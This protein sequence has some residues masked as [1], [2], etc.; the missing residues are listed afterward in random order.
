VPAEH[1]VPW[2]RVIRSSGHIAFPAGSRGWRR[3]KKQL[4]EEGVTVT[5]G[6]VDMRV[7]RWQPDLDELLWKPSAAWDGA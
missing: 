7:Y 2:H 6:R 1:A 4:Q 5:K 3:P